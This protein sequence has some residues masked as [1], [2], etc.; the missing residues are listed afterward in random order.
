M[1]AVLKSQTTFARGL[2]LLG[3]LSALIACSRG[4]WKARV[5]ANAEEQIR[6]DVHDRS[7]RFLGVQV[8]G[9][10]STGQTCGAVKAKLP[11]GGLDRSR[12]FIVY[13]DETAGPYIESEKGPHALSQED[14]DRA[15]QYDCLNEGYRP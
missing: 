13:I 9:D 10:S 5:I 14:F 15:W 7:A 11:D 6:A 4:N 1:H 3:A 2:V 12:R 8:T